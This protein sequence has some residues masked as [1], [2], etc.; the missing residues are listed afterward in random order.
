MFKDNQQT[1]SPSLEAHYQLY[2]K[3]EDSA[4]FISSIA[5]QYTIGS[6]ERLTACGKRTTRRA[7][8]LAIGFLGDYASNAVLGRALHDKDR[9]VRLLAEHGLR[10]LWFRAGNTQQFHRLHQLVRLND[11]GQYCD[12]IDIASEL[13]DEAPGLA[14]AWN[15]RAI[16][17]YGMFEFE[18][19]SMDCHQ[20]LEINPYHFNAAMGMGHCYLQME[21]PE[22]ALDCFR[23]ALALNPSLENVRLQIRHLEKTVGQDWSEE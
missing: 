16:A 17:W 23:R 3:N 22:L 9:A 1:R 13:I 10:Q 2:L 15:Q 7:A 6:L 4:Q 21:D 12:A 20:T 11:N 19:S 8:A 14:E 18:D 5:A